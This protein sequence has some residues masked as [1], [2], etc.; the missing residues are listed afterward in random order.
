[1]HV[2]AAMLLRRRQS[3]LDSSFAKCAFLEFR[4]GFFISFKFFLGSPLSF[5]PFETGLEQFYPF[6][7]AMR[8]TSKSFRVQGGTTHR[9]FVRSH[10]S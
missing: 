2:A 4:D 6:E 10:V 8:D 9:S 3:F 7:T 1:M 5:S